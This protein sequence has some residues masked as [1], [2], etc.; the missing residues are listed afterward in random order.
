MMNKKFFVKFM[1]VVGLNYSYYVEAKDEYGAYD[2]AKLK[3]QWAIGR[4]AAK[5]WEMEDCIEENHD[6]R[7]WL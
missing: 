4:D 5:D 2:A 3:L 1:P 6:G 7:R